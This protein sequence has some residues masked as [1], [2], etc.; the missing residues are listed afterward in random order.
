MQNP[1][2][3]TFGV[4]PAVLGGDDSLTRDFGAG[5]D[6]GPGDPRRTLL[7]SGPRGIGKT[8]A[9][10]ELEDEAARHGWVV[11]RAQPYELISPLVASVIPTT[12]SSLRQKNPDRRRIT[13][14]NIAGIGGFSTETPSSEKPDPSLIGSLNALCDALPQGSGALLTLDEVQSVDPRELWQLTAAVQDLRRDGRD[15]AFAAAGLPDGVTTL[16]QHPGT[17]FLRR[18]Q[19]VVLAPMTPTETLAVLKD[20]ARQG[21]VDIPDDVLQDAAAITRGYPFLIQ[22]LGYHLYERA[23]HRDRVVSLNDLTTV[24]PEVLK[25][26]GTLVHEPALLHVP[27]SELQYLEAMAEVQDGQRAVPSAAI[28]QQLGKNMQ[29][30]SMARQKLID[31]ELIYTPRRGLLNFVIPHMGHHLKQRAVRETGWD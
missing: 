19:H 11:L 26:L 14:V 7:I 21:A 12:L 28:A 6:G 3:P 13:G 22:L 4:S 1:F 18:A 17:T 30:L 15:V 23:N 24:T 27:A 25:T 31:R 29:Q 5:L 8:V 9:L 2:I 20:T 16:L 10:N